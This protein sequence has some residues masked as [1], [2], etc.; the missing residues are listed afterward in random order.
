MQPRANTDGS[1]DEKPKRKEYQPPKLICWGTVK[2]IV[3][4]AGDN[5]AEDYSSYFLTGPNSS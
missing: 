5:I 1:S 3:R 4:A 2:D